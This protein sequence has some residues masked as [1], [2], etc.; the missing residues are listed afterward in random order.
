[1]SKELGMSEKLVQSALN[2][3]VEM[4]YAEIAGA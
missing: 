4:G 3:L 2:Y 1:M